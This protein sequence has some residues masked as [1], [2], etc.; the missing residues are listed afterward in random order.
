MLF[1]VS[2]VEG[3]VRVVGGVVGVVGVVEFSDE[4]VVVSVSLI[5]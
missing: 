4:V 5:A 3:V 1:E 2:S